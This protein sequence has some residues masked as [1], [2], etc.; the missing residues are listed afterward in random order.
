M[1]IFSFM[2]KSINFLTTKFKFFFIV[3]LS[4]S[5]TIFLALHFANL[6]FG[7]NSYE[8]YSALNDKKQYLNQE[9]Y[10]LQHENARLQKEYFELK[11][12]EP[13]E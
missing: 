12:L 11:N 4:I 5:F 7:N 3:I 13:G 6:L 2:H 8:V 9:I 10:R 1:K